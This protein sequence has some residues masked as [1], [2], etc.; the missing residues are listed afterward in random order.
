MEAVKELQ[1]EGYSFSVEG[2]NIR[3]RLRAG[4]EPEKEKV[5]LLLAEL[6]AHK[7]EAIHFLEACRTTAGEEIVEPGQDLRMITVFS[8]VLDREVFVSWHSDNPESVFLDGVAYTIDEIAKLKEMPLTPDDLRTIHKVK[9]A[10][11]GN[12]ESSANVYLG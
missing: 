8:R 2:N 10:F 3:Y 4:I 9:T 11:E 1:A 5:S 7:A 6:K 12:I